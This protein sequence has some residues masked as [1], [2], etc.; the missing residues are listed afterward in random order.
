MIRVKESKVNSVTHGFKRPFQKF[1]GNTKLRAWIAKLFK[2][3]TT[4]E[5]Y[6]IF[7][8]VLEGNYQMISL[9]DILIHTKG[10]KF[11][12]DKISG[13]TFILKKLSPFTMRNLVGFKDLDYQFDL[14]GGGIAI[15]GNAFVERRK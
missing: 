3:E 10:Y 8:V 9:G 14:S 4:I 11:L 7:G 2:K 6:I 5:H 12:V 15:L 13:N 1:L